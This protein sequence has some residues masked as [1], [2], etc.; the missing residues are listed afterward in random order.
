MT[1]SAIWKAISIVSFRSWAHDRCGCVYRELFD[2]RRKKRV[3]DPAKA[4][5]YYLRTRKLKGRQKGKG[6]TDH[7]ESK[8]G[9]DGNPINP[10]I[11]RVADAQKKLDQSKLLANKLPAVKRA[12]MKK[13]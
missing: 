7:P 12:V 9:Y 1:V 5:A 10:A 6:T 3:Y 11:Q 8:M 4:R 13:S 2:A